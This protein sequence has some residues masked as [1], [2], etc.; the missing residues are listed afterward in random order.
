MGGR[1]REGRGR[2]G[3]G[4]RVEVGKGL[5][6]SG[7]ERGRG[8]DTLRYDLSPTKLHKSPNAKIV[9]STIVHVNKNSTDKN[10]YCTHD[11]TAKEVFLG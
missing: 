6:G 2:R 1:Q 9:N 10:Y 8:R 11:T 5:R 7:K 4:V 3:V